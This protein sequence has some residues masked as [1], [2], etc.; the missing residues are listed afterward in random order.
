ML[1]Y[2]VIRSACVTMWLIFKLHNPKLNLQE[3]VTKDLE[4]MIL[5]CMFHPSLYR[6]TIQTTHTCNESHPAKQ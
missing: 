6:I 5:A 2:K 3:N 1:K 4:K